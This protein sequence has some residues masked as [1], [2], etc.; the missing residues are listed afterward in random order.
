MST[1]QL[2]SRAVEHF[3]DASI[4]CE[5][6]C[7]VQVLG[8]K[9]LALKDQKRFRITVSDGAKKATVITTSQLTE[10]FDNG[11]VPD[12][13]ILKVN[14]F[15]LMVGAKPVVSLID[16]E[17]VEQASNVIGSPVSLK[18]EEP[19]VKEGS[20]PVKQ[21]IASVTQE[22]STTVKEEEK[23]PVKAENANNNMEVDMKKP[24]ADSPTP[25]GP[26][27]MSPTPS[28][29][30]A[31][32]VSPISMSQ[33]AD[34]L[35][36]ISN[37]NPYSSTKIKGRVMMK[38]EVRS[39]NGKA[40]G[41]KKVFSIVIMD[42][43]MDVKVTFWDGEVD[44]YYDVI[45][46]GKSYTFKFGMGAVK[47]GD[48][49][50]PAKCPYVV[51]IN[52][53]GVIEQCQDNDAPKITYHFVPIDKMEPHIKKG[54][55]DVLAVLHEVQ[56]STEIVIK[57]GAQAGSTKSKRNCTLVDA[58]GK[59]IFLT[60][61]DELAGQLEE[62]DGT[63]HAIIACR[64]IRVGDYGGCSLSSSRMS[65][66]ELDP[67]L[68]EAKTLRAWY[69]SSSTSSFTSV[70]SGA[71]GGAAGQP[72]P[73]KLISDIEAEGLGKSTVKPDY[74]SLTASVVWVNDEKTWQYPSNPKTKTKVVQQGDSWYDEKNS[75]MLDTCQRRYILPVSFSDFTGRS[76]LTVFD[77]DAK[78]IFGGISADEMWEM[79]NTDEKRFKDLWK[80]I[81]FKTWT[82]R[83]R[84]KSESFQ[85]ETRVKCQ[86]V[87]MEP[88]NF[89]SESRH[90]LER[91]RRYVN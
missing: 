3:F 62:T 22:S 38:E 41:T 26:A 23:T 4:P 74:L 46:V 14:D 15:T 50:N 68:P 81:M 10:F 61:W 67:D 87:S 25:K 19:K 49:F 79:S 86:A 16:V 43:T 17:I 82:I 66:I 5:K 63:R 52:S 54:S 34:N 58:S 76:F 13:T 35:M 77:D 70:G 7:I 39:F 89:V 64:G 37:M 91:I 69:D 42:D 24:E 56:S 27:L 30:K 11:K 1:T 47:M 75:E 36:P 55:V 53:K 6:P 80:S 29:P 65:T 32:S 57:N 12:N 84:A 44:K 71:T 60:L 85:E 59:Q 90:L 20:S 40:G 83:V 8:M 48:K 18:G 88:V 31:E 21:Q 9:E 28:P 2:T 78:K 33:S 51:T 73:R 72:A 45:E